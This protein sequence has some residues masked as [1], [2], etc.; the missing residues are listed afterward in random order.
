[1][2]APAATPLLVYE[3]LRYLATGVYAVLRYL[4]SVCGYY[5]VLVYESLSY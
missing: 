2:Q 5:Y 3:A 4:A 1:V